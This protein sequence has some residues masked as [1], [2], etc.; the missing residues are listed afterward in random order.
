MQVVLA[1][2]VGP[3]DVADEGFDVVDAEEQAARFAFHLAALDLRVQRVMEVGRDA[4]GAL[5]AEGGAVDEALP[6]PPRPG[7]VPAVQ[8]LAHGFPMAVRVIADEGRRK[9]RA[10]VAERIV[11]I[12]P[13]G[14]RPAPAHQRIHLVAQPAAEDYVRQP[15][16]APEVHLRLVEVLGVQILPYAAPHLPLLLCLCRARVLP[17][18]RREDA[19]DHVFDFGSHKSRSKNGE[20]DDGVRLSGF[21]PAS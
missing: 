15:G 7:T 18:R 4:E 12:H 19:A 5:Q 10:D 1:A 21:K 9:D 6:V 13:F 2:F 3:G 16:V 8:R 14:F 11:G 20:A 17:T